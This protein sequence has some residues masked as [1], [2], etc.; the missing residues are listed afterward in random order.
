MQ[1][2]LANARSR[3][4]R[5]DALIAMGTAVVLC[6]ELIASGSTVPRIYWRLV[7]LFTALTLLGLSVG[8]GFCAVRGFFRWDAFASLLLLPVF[9]VHLFFL[10]MGV[11]TFVEF[12]VP[13]PGPRYIHRTPTD[14]G[15]SDHVPTQ[16][17]PLNGPSAFQYI[18]T[19]APQPSTISHRVPPDPAPICR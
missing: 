1:R 9:F 5:N 2:T 7:T 13:P 18:P 8:G 11:A 19:T 3:S 14:V 17:L 15:N 6:I 12:L 4:G 10:Y 16:Q